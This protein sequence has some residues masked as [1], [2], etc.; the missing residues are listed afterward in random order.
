MGRGIPG[1]RPAPVGVGSWE[2][3]WELEL[4]SREFAD[5]FRD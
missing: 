5:R 2:L 1:C 4:G 3:L